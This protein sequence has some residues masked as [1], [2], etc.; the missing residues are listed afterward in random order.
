VKGWRRKDF[1]EFGGAV[2]EICCDPSEVIKNV[3][4]MPCDSD[5]PLGVVAKGF[6]KETEETSTAR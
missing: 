2:G 3:M 6:L 5:A 4:H 1:L